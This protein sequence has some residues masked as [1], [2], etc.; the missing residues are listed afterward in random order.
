MIR[1]Q[2][3]THNRSVSGHSAWDALYCTTVTVTSFFKFY[4]YGDATN[5]CQLIVNSTQCFTNVFELRQ[6]NVEMIYKKGLV[7]Q[8]HELVAVDILYHTPNK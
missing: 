4:V 5:N 3:G 7:L 6:C 2:M 1:T 8:K